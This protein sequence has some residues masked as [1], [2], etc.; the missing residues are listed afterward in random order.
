MAVVTER[1]L[2]PDQ[3]VRM[4]RLNDNE[5]HIIIAVPVGYVIDKVVPVEGDD[6]DRRKSVESFLYVKARKKRE[7]GE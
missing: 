6:D 7:F 3:L 5:A 4:R 2:L 1:S